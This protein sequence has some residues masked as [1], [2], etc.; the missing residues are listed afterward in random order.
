MT[1]GKIFEPHCTFRLYIDTV[2]ETLSIDIQF[3]LDKSTQK[4][5]S[6]T[7]YNSQVTTRD[8]SGNKLSNTF[9]VTHSVYFFENRSA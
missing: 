5:E 6:D 3:T 9:T 4:Y 7:K 2:V 1:I 8:L